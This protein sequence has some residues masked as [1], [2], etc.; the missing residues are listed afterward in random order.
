MKLLETYDG[1]ALNISKIDLNNSMTAQGKEIVEDNIRK[2][3]IEKIKQTKEILVEKLDAIS[4]QVDKLMN[5]EKE[6][7]SVKNSNSLKFKQFLSNFEHEKKIAE[8]RLKKYQDDQLKRDI[9]KELDYDR[10]TVKIKKDETKQKLRREAKLKKIKS[11]IDIIVKER[12]DFV[13]HKAELFKPHLGEKPE[14][15]SKWLHKRNE[16]EYKKK[17]DNIIKEVKRERRKEHRQ[18]AFSKEEYEEFK[19]FHEKKR[20]ELLFEKEQKRLNDLE[21]IKL[22]NE[23]LPKFESLA[24][25]KLLEENKEKKENDSVEKYKPVKKAKDRQEFCNVVKDM[26]LPRINEDQKKEREDRIQKL[27]AKPEVKK[28]K[29]KHKRVLLKKADRKSLEQKYK[30]KLKLDTSLDNKMNKNNRSRS[31]Q[32]RLSRSRSAKSIAN[33]ILNDSNDIIDEDHVKTEEAKRKKSRSRSAEKRKPLEKLPDY[34]T[35]MRIRKSHMEKVANRSSSLEK[36]HSNLFISYQYF[37]K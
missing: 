21:E 13:K 5:D 15:E 28:H 26:F 8:E 6:N 25:K 30:W 7:V 16:E 33:K 31:R 20:L 14:D 11:N 19:E 27:Y 29:R 37:R 22:Q 10:I 1:A 24:Y 17:E 18:N 23:N 2:A 36:L 35:E 34:L 9:L 4:E 32:P 3:Q 12:K